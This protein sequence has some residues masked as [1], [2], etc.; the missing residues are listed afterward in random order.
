M[1]G[2][3]TI[4]VTG[5]ARGVQATARYSSSG[6][7]STFAGYKWSFRLEN[8]EGD[9]APARLPV[10]MMVR[11]MPPGA[12]ADGD[13][14][15]VTGKMGRGGDLRGRRIR[16]LKTGADFEAARLGTVGRVVAAVAVLMILGWFVFIAILIFR[17]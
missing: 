14:V 13:R 10:T 12:I 1:G 17:G 8:P 15:E 3:A 9:G 6:H 5:E 16:N 2:T 4:V 7:S 11:R